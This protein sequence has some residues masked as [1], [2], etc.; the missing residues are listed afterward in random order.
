VTMIDALPFAGHTRVFWRARN[1]ASRRVY[2]EG[3][4]TTREKRRR[5][6]AVQFGSHFGRGGDGSPNAFLFL[7]C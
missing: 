7:E 2:I 4:L 6:A 3:R 1:C 5:T